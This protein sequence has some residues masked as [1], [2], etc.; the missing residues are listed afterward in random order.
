MILILIAVPCL[1]RVEG[2]GGVRGRDE[3]EGRGLDDGLGHE[4]VGTTDDVEPTERARAVQWSV[5]S[6]WGGEADLKALKS[7][8]GLSPVNEARGSEGRVVAG[9]CEIGGKWW[10]MRERNVCTETIYLTEM[11]F[12]HRPAEAERKY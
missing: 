11:W 6:V 8:R 9:K 5:I 7:R 3:Q 2:H 4:S 1:Q 10:G 12:K